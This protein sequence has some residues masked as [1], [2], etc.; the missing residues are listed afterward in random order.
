MQA[1]I[2]TT[3][4]GNETW[5]PTKVLA[6][7]VL[8]PHSSRGQDPCIQHSTCKLGE[9]VKVGSDVCGPA[10]TRFIKL[11]REETV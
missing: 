6:Q 2:A 7:S 3:N 10:Q 5:P 8:Y 9:V 1:N 4:D 11:V